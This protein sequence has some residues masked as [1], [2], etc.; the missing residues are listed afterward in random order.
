MVYISVK[1][2][3]TNDRGDMVKARYCL[4][5][6]VLIGVILAWTGY[7]YFAWAWAQES[8]HLAAAMLIGVFIICPIL[9]VLMVL[10][11]GLL[12]AIADSRW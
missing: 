12:W 4:M 5:G 9:I 11:C 10:L 6:T 7:L 2:Y 8:W 3:R 1:G